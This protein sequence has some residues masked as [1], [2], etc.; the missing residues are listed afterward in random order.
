[1]QGYVSLRSGPAQEE[2]QSLGEHRGQHCKF[3]AG[4]IRDLHQRAPE[5]SL[6]VLCRK[7]ETIGRLIYEMRQLG[8]RLVEQ[9]L[10]MQTEVLRIFDD[11]LG[12]VEIRLQAISR[13][14]EH[15]AG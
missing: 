11:R 1:M 9:M 8:D 14:D 6:G 2:G 13:L 5:R 15:G 7:N 10:D 4:K 3:V 12:P